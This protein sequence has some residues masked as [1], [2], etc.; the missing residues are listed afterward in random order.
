M[1]ISQFRV[2]CNHLRSPCIRRYHR[3]ILRKRSRHFKALHRSPRNL[4]VYYQAQTWCLHLLSR[5][6]LLTMF[7]YVAALQKPTRSLMKPP[8]PH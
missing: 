3:F 5:M 1:L 7:D 8:R 2:Y 6:S 4:H